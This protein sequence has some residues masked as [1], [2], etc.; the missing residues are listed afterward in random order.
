MQPDY[1]TGLHEFLCSFAA[2]SEKIWNR[3]SIITIIMFTII[4]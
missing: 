2:K 1:A 3:I 4:R